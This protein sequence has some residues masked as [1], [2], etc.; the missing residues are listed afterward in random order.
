MRGPKAGAAEGTGDPMGEELVDR[1]DVEMW[2]IS[3]LMLSFNKE[4]VLT[5]TVAIETTSALS[6]TVVAVETG[7]A[8]PDTTGVAGSLSNKTVEILSIL[9]AGEAVVAAVEAAATAVEITG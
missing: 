4:D 8:A 9:R 2:S 6:T 7:F 3:F 1:I 5:G